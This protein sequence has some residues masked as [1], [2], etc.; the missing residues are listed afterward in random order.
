MNVR[1]WPKRNVKRGMTMYAGIFIGDYVKNMAFKEH[2]SGM[3]LSQ[4]LIKNKGY[5][6]L[7]D[8]TIHCDIKAEA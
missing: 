2:N 6:I 7:L 1:S 3:T 5:K 8:F 4:I